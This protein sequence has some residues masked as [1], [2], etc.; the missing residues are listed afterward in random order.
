MPIISVSE[1]PIRRLIESYHFL[2]NLI[3]FYQNYMNLLNRCVHILRCRIIFMS[4]EK[5]KLT[6]LTLIEDFPDRINLPRRSIRSLVAFTGNVFCV[7][8]PQQLLII[9]LEQ[10]SCV[11]SNARNSCSFLL[12]PILHNFI[13]K[14]VLW[15]CMG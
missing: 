7:F 15:E 2:K 3:H 12:A 6:R 1:M 11:T 14:M 4:F 5:S 13:Q 8:M 9:R 10:Y